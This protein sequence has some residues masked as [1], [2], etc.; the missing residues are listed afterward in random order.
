MVTWKVIRGW[1]LGIGVY[2]SVDTNRKLT[3][4]WQVDGDNDDIA[5]LLNSRIRAAVRNC[6]RD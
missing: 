5:R 2:K 1:I 4:A 3:V 6:A